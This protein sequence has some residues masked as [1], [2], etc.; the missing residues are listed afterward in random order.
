MTTVAFISYRS[1]NLDRRIGPVSLESASTMARE[2]AR[3][4]HV[5][6]V[7]LEE[8]TC[9]RVTPVAPAGPA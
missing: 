2:L 9:T 8:W 4:A 5:S 7:K 3:V 1:S 6:E